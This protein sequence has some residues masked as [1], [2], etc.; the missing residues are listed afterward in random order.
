MTFKVIPDYPDYEINEEGVVRNINRQSVLKPQTVAKYRVVQLG[1]GNQRYVHDLV[2]LTFVGPKQA[3]CVRHIDGDGSNNCLSNL[4]YG[5]FRQ[6][7]DDRQ[8]HGTWGWKLTERHVRVIRGL[9]NCGFNRIRLSEIFG[10][11]TKHITEI[12]KRKRWQHV[13]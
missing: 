12:T 13:T 8:R 9:W 10:I 2:M 5:S 3:D 7:S 11:S 1:K 4:E 6:N